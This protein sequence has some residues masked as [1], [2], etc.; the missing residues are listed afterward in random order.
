M[1]KYR[2]LTERTHCWMTTKST[3]DDNKEALNQIKSR[4]SDCQCKKSPVI[5]QRFREDELVSDMAVFCPG[6]EKSAPKVEEPGLCST[7][8]SSGNGKPSIY[9][10]CRPLWRQRKKVFKH[11]PRIPTLTS[12]SG[13]YQKHIDVT[14]IKTGWRTSINYTCARHGA[15][16]GSHRKLFECLHIKL[17]T[18]HSVKPNPRLPTHRNTGFQQR[19]QSTGPI[20]I[21]NVSNRTWEAI[22]TCIISSVSET[23]TPTTIKEKHW[24]TQRTDLIGSG[25]KILYKQKHVERTKIGI[26]N[27][28]VRILKNMQV[29]I[30][31]SN[32]IA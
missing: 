25:R 22:K 30:D 27:E 14:L 32:F 4:S 15:I 19:L 17:K 1:G 9:A 12:P 10:N 11:H 28:C 16:C 24:M 20:S 23:K 26:S 3:Q 29:I 31:H 7:A 18:I 21:G 6:I 5:Y 8:R 2:K 13:V